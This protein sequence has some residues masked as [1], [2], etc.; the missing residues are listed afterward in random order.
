MATILLATAPV[1]QEATPH[2]KSLPHWST[3]FQQVKEKADL[4]KKPLLLLFLGGEECPWSK[5]MREELLTNDLFVGA[6]KDKMGLAWI[7]CSTQQSLMETYGVQ[8]LPLFLL[9]EPS[10]QEM[11]RVHYLPLEASQFAARLNEI[12]SVHKQLKEKLTHVDAAKTDLTTLYQEAKKSEL[13]AMQ[14]AL[15]KMG[16]ETSRAPFFLLEKYALLV[17]AGERRSKEARILRKEILELDPEN[18]QGSILSLALL[19]FYAFEEGSKR[20]QDVVKPL[21]SYLEQFGDVDTE[22]RWQL[23][24][25]VA[26]FFFSKDQLARALKHAERSLLHAPD[27][28]KSELAASVAYIKSKN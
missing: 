26:Q 15:L 18:Q 19:D 22:H 25:L 28:M 7:D 5:K 10:G 13:H 14:E 1:L 20:P 2:P 9:L 23:E 21:L 12:V 4:E 16:L 6:L 11:S 17:K 3:D 24:W 8:E 27:E